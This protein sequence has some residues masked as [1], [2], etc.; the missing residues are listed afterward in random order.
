M[1]QVKEASQKDNNPEEEM[2]YLTYD[3]LENIQTVITFL[4]GMAEDSNFVVGIDVEVGDLNG[5]TL[6]NVRLT[7]SRRYGFVPSPES[8]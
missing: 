5:E 7:D 6:G 3:E 1:A 4:E 8:E 2:T